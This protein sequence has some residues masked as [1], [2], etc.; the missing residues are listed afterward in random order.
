[1]QIFPK[2]KISKNFCNLLG[3]FISRKSGQ[4]C[5]VYGQNGKPLS[6]EVVEKFLIRLKTNNEV[7]LAEAK[8][9]QLS[10]IEKSRRLIN[11]EPVEDYTKL[12]RLFY[13]RNVFL[14][15]D[16]IKEIYNL[17]YISNL[18]QIPNISLSNQ[19]VFKI[20]LYTPPLKGLSF[21]DL[22]LATAINSLNFDKFKLVPLRN[23]SNYRREIR[24]ITIEDEQKKSESEINERSRFKNKYD[25]LVYENISFVDNNKSGDINITEPSGCSNP[26][27]CACKQSKKTKYEL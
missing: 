26:E 22:Q 12:F 21:R 11:W 7:E 25:A 24:S 20:E 23:E 10:Q 2:Y 19:E 15:T 5:C 27:G 8:Y 16:F 9:A 1:M 18:H 14:L 3:N 17:D 13:F 4:K 6:K